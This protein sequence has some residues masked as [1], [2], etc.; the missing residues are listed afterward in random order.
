LNCLKEYLKWIIA[1]DEFLKHHQF[2]NIIELS[3]E[4]EISP[5]PKKMLLKIINS[6]IEDKG[7]EVTNNSATSA[8]RL[9]TRSKV[10]YKKKYSKK[11]RNT[12]W[13]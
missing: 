12:F 13:S 7:L 1:L 10:N 2:D 6:S 3:P 4:V 9:L 5:A 11:L 8:I